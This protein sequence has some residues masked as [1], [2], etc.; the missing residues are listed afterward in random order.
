MSIDHGA[1]NVKGR[2][3]TINGQLDK[4]FKDLAANSRDAAKYN[5]ERM[6]A[7]RAEAK[8]LVETH[9]HNL[10]AVA[11]LHGTN[12]LPKAMKQLKSD[13]HWD[14]E[15]VITMMKIFLA[16]SSSGRQEQPAEAGDCTK[17]EQQ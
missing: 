6:K 3:S 2:T 15:K 4:H 1:L 16:K 10:A 14:P 12:T 8:K 5:A 11:V 9:G 17:G 7:L 13:A